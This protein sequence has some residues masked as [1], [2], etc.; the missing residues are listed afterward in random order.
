M[1][2]YRDEE[3]Y[4]LD[5]PHA[6]CESRESDVLFH[7][8]SVIL[9]AG[10]PKTGKTTIALALA[11]ALVHGREFAGFKLPKSTVGYL[12]FDDSLTE[13][14]SAVREH[15]G[16]AENNDFFVN[17]KC[18]EIDSAFS[19]LEIERFMV[20]RSNVVI[21]IDSLHA[22]IQQTNTSNPRSIRR[23]F[24]SLTSMAARSGT[25]ILLHHTDKRGRTI[26]DHAQI[27]A[28]ASQTIIHSSE[29]N[30]VEGTNVRTITWKTVGRGL[31]LPKVITFRSKSI[32]SY[33]RFLPYP[34]ID[35]RDR[36]TATILKALEWNQRTAF[37][38]AD[39]TNLPRHRIYKR[40]SKL[41]KSGH[42]LRVE[43]SPTSYALAKF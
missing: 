5:D 2:E 19:Q 4:N 8:H 35:A 28:A 26:A 7:P 9:L 22:A 27:Q 37:E 42:V 41:I 43:T 11:N 3:F 23:L 15:P 32:E 36:S 29:D 14:A 25:I 38:I 39:L 33:E 16:L 40:L 24:S 34:A 18:S 10:A 20:R 17:T 12:S 21:I 6:D 13:I 30:L 31:G 1:N